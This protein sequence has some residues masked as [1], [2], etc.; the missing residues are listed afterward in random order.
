MMKSRGAL[1]KIGRFQNVP[2]VG[3]NLG[4]WSVS[5]PPKRPILPNLHLP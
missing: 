1:K 5:I 2:M 4:E 3:T